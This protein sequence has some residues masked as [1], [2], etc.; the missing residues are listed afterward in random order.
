MAN[1]GDVFSTGQTC[2]ESGV[3]EYSG[4]ANGPG[5]SVSPEQREIPLAKGNTFPPVRGCGHAARWK[6]IRY[7]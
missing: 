3:Y 4:H 7:A 2:Q 1:I 5:C 6:L